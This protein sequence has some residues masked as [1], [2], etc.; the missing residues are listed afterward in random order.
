LKR[1]EEGGREGVREKF[2]MVHFLRDDDSFYF[3]T[4]IKRVCGNRDVC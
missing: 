2:A 1:S 4:R 3:G